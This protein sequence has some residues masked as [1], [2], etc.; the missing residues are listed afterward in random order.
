[1][2]MNNEKHMYTN[3]FKMVMGLYDCLMSFAMT[4]PDISPTGEMIGEI[5]EEKIDI[6]TSPLHAKAI[7][8]MLKAH[9]EAYEAVN[10]ELKLPD[11]IIK[12]IT[13]LM[14]PGK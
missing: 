12:S 9:I 4:S 7:Y 6:H 2:D 13:T 1:M 5:I 14:G 8:I 11:A 10:G 3:S